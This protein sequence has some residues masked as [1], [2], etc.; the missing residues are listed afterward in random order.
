MSMKNFSALSIMTLTWHKISAALFSYMLRKIILAYFAYSWRSA[1][2]DMHKHIQH[3][4]NKYLTLYTAYI[5]DLT[6]T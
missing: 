1:K 5:T 6:N 4:Q 2:M 3:C